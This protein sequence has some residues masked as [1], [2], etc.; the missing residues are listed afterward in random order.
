MAIQ[1]FGESFNLIKLSLAR[2]VARDITFELSSLITSGMTENDAHSIYKELCKKYP[3]EKQW[4]PPKFRFGPNTLKNFR[5]PSEPYILQEEDIFFIDI[6]PVVEGHEADYGE[7]FIL[8]DQFEHKQIASFSQTL[9]KEVSSYW[10]RENI[11]GAKLYQFAKERA[12]SHDFILNEY[13]AGHRIG[14]FPHHV[15]FK[16]KLPECKEEIIPNAWILEIHLIHPEKKFGAFFE[17]LL[18]RDS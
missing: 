1:D 18:T 2:D 17:D 14:D 12:R 16:G 4:H 7:T 9:F 10:S 3:V 13:S 11:D 15:H 5:D 8:G 6:G